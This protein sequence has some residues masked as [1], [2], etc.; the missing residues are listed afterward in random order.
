[1]RLPVGSVRP[2]SRER[3]RTD[4]LLVAHYAGL[5]ELEGLL[6]Q[7]RA[8]DEPKEGKDIHYVPVWLDDKDAHGHYDGYCKQSEYAYLP[9]IVPAVLPL[10]P[11][12][13]LFSPSL[14]LSP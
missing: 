2:K 11:V 14:V 3:K 8:R 9:V 12:S 1:M 13:R 7:Y 4:L 10:S 5:D 6:D